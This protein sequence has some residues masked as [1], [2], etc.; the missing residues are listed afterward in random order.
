M[1]VPGGTAPGT[2]VP[3]VSTAVVPTESTGT[4]G[5]AV[6]ILDRD[7]LEG[8]LAARLDAHAHPLGR[9]ALVLLSVD[10]LEWVSTSLGA[11]ATE[12]LLRRVGGRLRAAIG[13]G[14]RLVRTS[15]DE[16]ALIVEDADRNVDGRAAA[17]RLIGTLDSSLPLPGG[18]ELTVTAS[19]GVV[20]SSREARAADALVRNA[21][22]ALYEARAAGGGRA[23]VF[24]PPMH[25]A[26]LTRLDLVTDLCAALDRG[27]FSLEYQPVVRVER[28]RPEARGQIVY[29]EALLRW[30]HPVRGIVPPGEFIA[31]AEETGLILDIGEW[32]LREACRQFRT[33]HAQQPQSRPL[34]LSVNLS[35]RQFAQ[36]DLAERIGAALSDAGLPPESLLLELT[37]SSVMHDV[38]AAVTTLRAL[39]DRGI[40]VAL[41]DFGTG[42]SS[43]SYLAQLPIDVLKIDR[44]FVTRLGVA[45]AESAI[46]HA[47]AEIGRAL[48]YE[49]VAEG[50]ETRAQLHEIQSVGIELAQGFLFS[51][52]LGP[53]GL[54]ALLRSSRR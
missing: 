1:P 52:P 17:E 26:A 16:F 37:E 50:V 48:G 6:V 30:R 20:V 38:R 25:S 41:D 22:A 51:K 43:L 4:A 36:A 12:E 40:R 32:V 24:E 10:R 27:E 44:A 31:A 49:L 19:V 34:A 54:G 7:A 35:A 8:E 21:L 15:A 5:E 45:P 2:P 39:R 53:A 14:E 23:V 46:V 13:E 11:A 28:G 29:V 3:S 18:R 9:L 33:W 47:L 42:R